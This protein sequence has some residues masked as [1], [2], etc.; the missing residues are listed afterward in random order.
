MKKIYLSLAMALL[1][2]VGLFAAQETVLKTFEFGTSKNNPEGTTGYYLKSGYGTK[3]VNIPKA[4]FP[5]SLK[6]GDIVRLYYR[7]DISNITDTKLPQVQYAVKVGDAWTWTQLFDHVDLTG[8]DKTTG[9]GTFDYTIGD[10]QTVYKEYRDECEEFDDPFIA[11]VAEEIAAFQKDGLY[12]KGQ[13]AYLD[14][15]E[16]IQV[17]EAVDPDAGLTEKSSYEKEFDFGAWKN[18]VQIPAKTFKGLALGDKIR[19]YCQATGAEPQVQ[20]VYKDADW[21]WTPFVEA[22]DVDEYYEYD[23]DSDVVIENLV[24]RGMWLKGNDC[25]LVKVVVMSK[26]GQGGGDNP[27]KPGDLKIGSEWTPD[28]PL[29]TGS[30]AKEVVVP[31]SLFKKAD[32]K[33]VIRLLFSEYTGGQIQPVLK[34][35]PGYVWTQLADAID[36]DDETY[37][38]AIAEIPDMNAKVTSVEDAIKALQTSGLILKGKNIALKGA[39]LLVPDN[40]EPEKQYKVS[41]TTEF[42]PA[43]ES[44]NWGKEL[45]IL[46]G[47]FKK[48]TTESIIRLHMSEWQGGQ[49]QP[50]I[51]IGTGWTWTELAQYI[52]LDDKVFDLDI[53]EVSKL[54]ADITPEIMVEGLELDGLYL[55]GKGFV[56]TKMEILNPDNGEPEVEYELV[57]TATFDPAL[58]S[59]NWSNELHIAK[60]EFT[61]VNEQS[62]IKLIFST[63]AGGQM[64]PVVKLG[65][66]FTWTE[67]AEYIDLDGA[68]YELEV[69]KVAKLN[70][71]FTP[72][73]LV[74]GLLNDGLYLKGQKFVLTGM[75]IWN[76]KGSAVRDIATDSETIDWNAPVEIYN[77]QGVRVSDMT[78]GQLYIVRQGNVVEKVV[79]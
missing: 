25:T 10:T 41:S 24:A 2:V 45:H 78:P 11:D 63:Y 14:K 59:G 77:L 18:D 54:N 27:E 61:L 71:D 35:M 72:A 31:S 19:V 66:A 43:L 60:S 56:I 37:D 47:E 74:E 58:E 79:K 9:A 3:E 48:V 76:P 49:I 62:L 44:G 22:G 68:V 8:Y 16:V 51:K 17:G 5:K 69:A 75:E 39:Q 15:I 52:D 13:L 4:N 28:A 20:L 21:T 57:K 38:I 33:S 6:A 23:V 42:D 12:I 55:K 26:S 36:I 7:A 29:E 53:A 73:L 70:A 30:W 46:K 1:T 34:M 32:E 65:E 64:Q 40:G 67:I 50:V